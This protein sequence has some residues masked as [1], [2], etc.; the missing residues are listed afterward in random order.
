MLS[1]EA[2]A[3]ETIGDDALL[4]NP[5]DVSQTAE[6]LHRALST[7]ASE[8]SLT[9]QR[10]RRDAPGTAPMDWFQQQIDAVQSVADGA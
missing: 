8:R 2:G 10:L 1:R 3:V 5:F 6:A 4:V 7:P 9:A